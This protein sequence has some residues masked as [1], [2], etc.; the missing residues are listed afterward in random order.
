M[1]NLSNE[2][3]FEAHRGLKQ[4]PSKDYGLGMHWSAEER[5]ARGFAGGGIYRDPNASVW[6][7]A[8][9][10]KLPHTVIHAQVPISSVETD[11]K[12]MGQRGVFDPKSPSAQF[13]TFADI[14][15]EISVKPGAPVM[16]TGVTKYRKIERPSQSP[17]AIPG[18]S[19]EVRTK[20]RTR[21]YNP[22]RMVKA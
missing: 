12:T 15:K 17:Y 21:T 20:P 10:A 3:F 1:S 14:E 4:S 5:I 2:L 7:P 19:K 18:I 11:R 16:V 22:P 13:R 8:E 6:S 9:S